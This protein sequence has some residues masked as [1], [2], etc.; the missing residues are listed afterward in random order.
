[1][2]G[3]FPLQ[4]IVLEVA[5]ADKDAAVKLQSKVAWLMLVMGHCVA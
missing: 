3:I 4:V 1:M 2:A 5:P